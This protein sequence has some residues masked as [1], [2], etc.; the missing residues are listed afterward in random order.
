MGLCSSRQHPLV[1]VVL[2]DFGCL[3]LRLLVPDRGGKKADIVLG[4][5]SLQEYVV[6][7]PK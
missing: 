4:Y 2:S 7:S 1:Q 5:N 3:I 6:R